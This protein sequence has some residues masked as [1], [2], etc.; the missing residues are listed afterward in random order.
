MSWATSPLGSR[1]SANSKV[2]WY[3]PVKISEGTIANTEVFR[4]LDLVLRKT[5]ESWSRWEKSPDQSCISSF[6]RGCESLNA[7]CPFSTSWP[8]VSKISATVPETGAL[9]VKLAYW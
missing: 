6:W 4:F 8:P 7:S 9:K 2:R 1:G 5:E 3:A